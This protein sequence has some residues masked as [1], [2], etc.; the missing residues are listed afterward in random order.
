MEF[1]KARQFCFQHSKFDAKLQERV[2]FG[3]MDEAVAF[4]KI[5]VPDACLANVPESPQGLV[6][7][8]I[9]GRGAFQ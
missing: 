4:V 8:D 7:T 5:A 6:L 1:R 3:C 2:F 9:R